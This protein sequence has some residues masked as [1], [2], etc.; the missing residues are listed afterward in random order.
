MRFHVCIVGRCPFQSVSALNTCFPMFADFGN[1]WIDQ[2]QH[3]MSAYNFQISLTYMPAECIRVMA[4][5]IVRVELTPT[6]QFWTAILNRWTGCHLQVQ[7]HTWAWSQFLH[8]VSL[9]T[10]HLIPHRIYDVSSVPHS[11]FVGTWSRD[12]QVVAYKATRLPCYLWS[13]IR[14]SSY[15]NKK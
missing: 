4:L 15:I 6:F 5:A 10:S 1:K 2:Q 12:S 9:C 3:I 11:K 7:L 13:C 8:C 14:S